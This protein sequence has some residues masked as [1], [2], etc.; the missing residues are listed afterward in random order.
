MKTVW[1]IATLTLMMF[2]VSVC[3]FAQE[4]KQTTT[5]LNLERG[6]IGPIGSNNSWS[7]YTVFSL[8]PGAGLIPISS[9]NTVFYLGFTAG[10]TADIGNMVLYTTARASS[11][12]TAVTPVTY[13][14]VSNPSINLASP[15]VCPTQPLSVASPCIVRLDPTALSLSALSD[16][17]LAVYFTGGDVNNSGIG[18][19]Q[20]SSNKSSLLGWYIGGNADDT[21][22]TVGQTIPTGCCTFTDFLMY[23]M[24]N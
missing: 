14:A 22:L 24:S 4:Q 13:T 10:S 6:V 19:A 23:V 20:P 12:V 21:H 3:G 5:A 18:A 15:S 16:Y 11:T 8:V 1:T 17:Y 9:S 2:A 7:G